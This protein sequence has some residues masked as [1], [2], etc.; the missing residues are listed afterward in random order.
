MTEKKTEK[1]AAAPASQKFECDVCGF[2]TSSVQ[3]LNF[4]KQK[5]S[6]P[7]SVPIVAASKPAVAPS[8][9]TERTWFE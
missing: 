8:V 1:K 5:H 4:H 9:K 2:E 7:T 3:R 6:K